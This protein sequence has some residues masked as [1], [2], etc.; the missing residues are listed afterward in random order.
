MYFP[1]Q[2]FKALKE[3]F[4]EK[5]T[6]YL[7]V[8]IV[9]RDVLEVHGV[10]FEQQVNDITCML[11]DESRLRSGLVFHLDLFLLQFRDP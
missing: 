7:I 11:L 9:K 5:M 3:I 6:S 1:V 2:V 4:G 10:S 8:V